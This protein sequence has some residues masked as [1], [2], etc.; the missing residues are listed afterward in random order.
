MNTLVDR[1]LPKYPT[2][3][4]VY[5]FIGESP[6][7]CIFDIITAD[8]RQPFQQPSEPSTGTKV[9]F[10]RHGGECP[11]QDRD[12]FFRRANEKAAESLRPLQI[13]DHL[14]SGA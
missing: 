11:T 1:V 8:P 3:K 4:R 9:Q 6:P 2:L 10:G 12:V 13:D 7:M 5:N 14:W